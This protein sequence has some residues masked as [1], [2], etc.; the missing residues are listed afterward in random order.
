LARVLVTGGAGYVGSHVVLEL[1]AL[2]HEVVVL[3]DLSTGH[4]EA[5]P[6]EVELVALSLADAAAVDRLVGERRFEAIFH[7][8]ARS[9]VPE[10]MR[11]PLTYLGDNVE[12]ALA[13]IRAAVRHGVTRF[14]FSS[15]AALFGAPDTQPIAE[16][17]PIA[18][19]SP[20]GESK[21]YIERILRWTDRVSGLRYAALR[22]FNAAG[23]DPGLRA[24]EDHRPETHLVPR[25]LSV[26]LG[27]APHIEVFGSDYPTPDGTA[28]RDYVHVSDL[29]RAH[30]LV[31]GAL[32]GGSVELNLGSGTGFSVEQVLAMAR[33]VTGQPIPAVARPRRAGDPAVLVASN[34]RAREL[35]GWVPEHDLRSIVASAWAWHSAHPRG[36][37]A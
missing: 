34:R 33:E 14:V 11:D 28:I 18:P 37:G 17:A 13:L 23:A 24:G 6:A 1:V 16:D 35:L 19:G 5:V 26:A 3:D 7:F 20:Y 4:R 9:I 30:A 27:Q 2:G 25:V 15:T 8:A 31:L 10:S 36:Y 22:Y 12:T 29:A 21:H 32:D